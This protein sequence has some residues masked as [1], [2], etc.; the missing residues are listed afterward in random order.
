MV[1]MGGD[2]TLERD[3][4]WQLMME[5]SNF[6]NPAL[7]IVVYAWPMLQWSLIQLMYMPSY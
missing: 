5:M 3:R 4:L 7:L 6:D 2:N 1:A